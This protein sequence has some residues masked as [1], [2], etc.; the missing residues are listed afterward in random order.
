MDLIFTI[1]P[2]LAADF[3]IR[4]SLHENSHHQIIYRN[5]DLKIFYPPPYERTIWHYQQANTELIKR[6]LENSDWKKAF[7]NC[8]PNEQ[9]SVLTKT[10]FNITSNFK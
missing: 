9:V 2:N 6:P 3:G 5:F 7:S 4:P 8:N 1:Q 10:V